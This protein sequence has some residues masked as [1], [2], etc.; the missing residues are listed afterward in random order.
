MEYAIL[1]ICIFEGNKVPGELS[2]TFSHRYNQ[3]RLYEF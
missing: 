2:T 1:F 3:D